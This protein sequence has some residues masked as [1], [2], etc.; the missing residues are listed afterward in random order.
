MLPGGKFKVVEVA[1][2]P[3]LSHVEKHEG[4]KI[5]GTRCSVKSIT[6]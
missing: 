1:K 2:A 3:V 5:D 6:F 4:V